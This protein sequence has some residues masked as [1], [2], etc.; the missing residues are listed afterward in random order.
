VWNFLLMSAS[1]ALPI[2]SVIKLVAGRIHLRRDI[3]RT[4]TPGVSLQTRLGRTIVV[5]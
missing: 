1:P 4:R 5:D 3:V 2:H